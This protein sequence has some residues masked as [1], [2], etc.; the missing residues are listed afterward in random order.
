MIFIYNSH[1][2]CSII[3]NAV[4]EYLYGSVYNIHNMETIIEKEGNPWHC[5]IV[6]FMICMKN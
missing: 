4:V 1:E 2:K 3:V 5:Q 6:K